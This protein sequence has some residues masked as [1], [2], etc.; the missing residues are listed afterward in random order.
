LGEASIVQHIFVIDDFKFESK[1]R[2]AFLK[3][4]I[5]AWPD[6][7][8]IVVTRTRT[9]VLLESEF[10]K[11]VA[12]CTASICDVSFM[13]IAYF[14]Q[15]NFEMPAAASEVVA[16]RLRET[17]R[18]YALSAHPSYFAG[19]PVNTL[20]ALLQVNRRAELIELAVAGYLSFVVSEDVEPIAL[21]RT[22]REKFLAELVYSIKA[23]GRSF[24]EAQLTIYTEDFAKK[25]DFR[26]SPAR[27]V[28]LFIEKG[29]LHVEDGSI[30]FTLPFMESYL[31]AKWLTEDSAK[32]LNYFAIKPAGFDF[33]S[34]ALYAEM[35]AATELVNDVNQKLDSC[36]ERMIVD[37]ESTSVLLGNSLMPAVLRRQ[38]RL[39]AIQ[40]RLRQAEQEV[41]T[42]RDQSREKQRLLDANDRIREEAGAKLAQ[43][44]SE[45]GE[46]DPRIILLRDAAAAWTVAVSLLG[47]GAERLE[48]PTKREIAGKI[49]KLSVYIIDKWMMA[50][51]SVNFEEIKRKAVEAGFAREI[52]KSK[53]E[54]EL[55]EA[56]RTIEYIV[57]FVEYV[58]LL[59]PVVSIVS[60][61]CE[62]ARD[63]VLAESITNITVGETVEDL[64][65]NLWLSDI[66]VAKGSKGLVHAIKALPSAIFLRFAI[67]TH[68][69]ARVYWRHW[70]KEDRLL[71]LDAA[72]ESLKGA[73][74]QFNKS[75]LKR[76]IENLPDTEDP[77]F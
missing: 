31:L 3:E 52:A 50:H 71:L 27:F 19:I 77:D 7:K 11:N 15:K 32:A 41:R 46:S 21:S 64:V 43:T 30:R 5:D 25:Y 2:V 48:A 4:Q 75:E 54:D 13:E 65:R 6:A 29:I 69:I 40:E 24:S 74:V 47:A 59:Q 66:D 76:S 34:F 1:S 57:D 18:K 14:L 37:G 35:G 33:R 10:T 44:Q 42:D 23:E 60:H 63:K 36:I 12:S 49:I 56:T 73:G 68:L 72:S 45:Q 16:M 58:F 61:L 67:A 28:S 55:K 51:K 62:E 70:R 38:D 22:T 9:N 26:I 39:K 53:S 8:F 17:F 20:K